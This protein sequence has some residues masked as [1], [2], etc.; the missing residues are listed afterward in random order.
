V[1]TDPKS[2]LFQ[3][4]FHFGCAY[5]SIS[6][7]G[8]CLSV[9]MIACHPTRGPDSPSTL[10][11][12]LIHLLIMNQIRIE[13]EHVGADA[14]ILR[15]GDW[16]RSEIG[17]KPQTVF[18]LDETSRSIVTSDGRTASEMSPLVFER[19]HH[20]HRFFLMNRP[21][22]KTLFD[23]EHIRQSA[24]QPDSRNRIFE[25]LDQDQQQTYSETGGIAAID[26]ETKNLIFL[27]IPSELAVMARRINDSIS[28]L[29]V[30]EQL[31]REIRNRIPFLAIRMDRTIDVI[32]GNADY[33]TRFAYAS[34]FLELF[35]YYLR[36]T[37]YIDQS[38]QYSAIAREGFSGLYLGI[39]HVHPKD[40]P[41]SPEDRL[42][43]M[44]KRNLVLVPTDTGC[45]LH[46]LTLDGMGTDRMEVIPIP[47]SS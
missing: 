17:R 5:H 3:R 2:C 31:L 36:H 30:M 47:R 33:Q 38:S 22:D 11:D 21:T 14:E 7:I 35:N 23:I 46:Y 25:L 34:E 32:A 26:P 44:F 29:T 1:S 10:S 13:S 6:I 9:T 24:L 27:T 8:L 16:I 18:V 40:N 28:D 45:D 15:L 19:I 42:E 12:R 4:T 37:Y 41:P 20:L 39:F 43:S